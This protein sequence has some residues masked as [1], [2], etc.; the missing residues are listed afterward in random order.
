MK[1]IVVCASLLAVLAGSSSFAAEE[2][3]GFGF[4]APQKEHEWLRQFVGEWESEAESVGLPG[5]PEMKC[6]GT[7]RARMLGGFWV[8]SDVSNEMM[9]TKIEAIQTIGY[10][11]EKKKY[12]GTWVDSMLNHIW[13]YDGTVD[14]TGK[15]LTLEA[16]GPS[17]VQPGKTAL[18]RDVYEFKTKDHI[19]ATSL[20]QGDDGKWTV[21]MTGNVRRKK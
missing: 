14:A 16:E 17:F 4:P 20:M 10:D 6:K 1:S 5:Q 21:F 15:K 3:P 9:G 2:G 11:A 12:V 13:K 19:V 7:M 8:V 18:F